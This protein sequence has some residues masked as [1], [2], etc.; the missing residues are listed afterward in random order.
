MVS[1]IIAEPNEVYKHKDEIGIDYY[2]ISSDGKLYD[3]E[4]E[5][6][7]KS[8]QYLVNDIKVKNANFTVISEVKKG[9]VNHIYLVVKE[10]FLEEFN[11]RANDYLKN[12][13]LTFKKEQRDIRSLMRG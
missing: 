3:E 9:E 5:L 8:S 12:I 11:N 1:L 7:P 13:I 4:Q 10:E 2:T 6:E